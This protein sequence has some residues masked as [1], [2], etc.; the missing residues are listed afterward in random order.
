MEY[1]MNGV[2]MFDGQSGLEYEIWSRRTKAFL[3]HRDMIFGIQLLQDIM[4][5]RNQRL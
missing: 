1:N 5:Q 4:V 3:R 2:P